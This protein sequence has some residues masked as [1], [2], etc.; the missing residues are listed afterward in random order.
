M[1][2]DNVNSL[3]RVTTAGA[4]R[5]ANYLLV[6]QPKALPLTLPRSLTTS[7]PKRP[8][9]PMRVELRRSSMES[10]WTNVRK[11]KSQEGFNCDRFG[12]S[13][14][15]SPNFGDKKRIRVHTLFFSFRTRTVSITAAYK[16]ESMR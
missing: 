13:D 9:S 14:L 7:R 2:V 4:Q 10:Q 3:N 15:G 16:Y 1:T 12:I 6:R 8:S 11:G 5:E